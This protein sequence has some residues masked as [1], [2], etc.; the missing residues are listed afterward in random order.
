[1][2]AIRETHPDP[3]DSSYHTAESADDYETHEVNKNYMK[4]Y[5]KAVPVTRGSQGD[6]TGNYSDKEEENPADSSS[7]CSTPTTAILNNS[8]GLCSTLCFIIIQMNL[9]IKE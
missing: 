6:G 8:K 5:A 3:N 2:S 4:S 9:F 7:G 1:M